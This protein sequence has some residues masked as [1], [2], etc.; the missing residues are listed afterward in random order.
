MELTSGLKWMRKRVQT[1]Y[2]YCISKW[3]TLPSLY[4][5][6]ETNSSRSADKCSTNPQ[7]ILE[8]SWAAGVK[9]LLAAVLAP[10]QFYVMVSWARYSKVSRQRQN[11]PPDLRLDLAVSS[12]PVWVK[13]R[14]HCPL[15]LHC[16]TSWILLMLHI[17]AAPPLSS[18]TMNPQ[19]RPVL[20]QNLL[21]LKMLS[22]PGR[23]NEELFLN[24][25]QFFI[26]FFYRQP[27]LVMVGA[28]N[29]TKF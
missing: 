13:A 2:W 28:L 8:L 7:V 21:L 9:K 27:Q 26:Y 16:S 29:L 6:C 22:W 10:A 18:L 23:V 1:F 11:D 4:G 20:S 17:L 3:N 15:S 24:P 14:P 12:G 25:I 5:C 19:D